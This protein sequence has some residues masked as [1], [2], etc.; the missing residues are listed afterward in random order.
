VLRRLYIGSTV[1][2]SFFTEAVRATFGR[3]VTTIG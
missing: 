1:L 3:L 2:Q